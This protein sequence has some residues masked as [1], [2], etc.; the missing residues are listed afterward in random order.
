MSSSG[1]LPAFQ[2]QKNLILSQNIWKSNFINLWREYGTFREVAGVECFDRYRIDGDSEGQKRMSKILRQPTLWQDTMDDDLKSVH[3]VF[4]L[5]KLIAINDANVSLWL[6][7]YKSELDNYDFDRLAYEIENNVIVSS[8]FYLED[9]SIDDDFLDHLAFSIA[10]RRNIDL[11]FPNPRSATYDEIVTLDDVKSLMDA[12]ASRHLSPIGENPFDLGLIQ[13]EIQEYLLKHGIGTDILDQL[14]MD[15]T[16]VGVGNVSL[17]EM[18]YALP[19]DVA[20][21]MNSLSFIKLIQS[22]LDFIYKRVTHWYDVFLDLGKLILASIAFYFQQYWL[23]VSLLIS[24]VA[25]KVNS[26]LLQIVSTIVSLASGDI[27]SLG[28]MGAREAIEL[29]Q[30]VYALYVEISYTP[31]SPAQG[32]N[33]DNND[34]KM[35][36]RAPY[37]AYSGVY[38]YESLTSVDVD[39]KYY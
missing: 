27:S 21:H 18:T 37:D 26:R 19:V 24:F 25:D 5:N 3:L 20:Q 13:K 7:D 32:E 15:G 4:D 16:L 1:T 39:V 12:L 33:T 9:V 30:N 36:Y 35:F 14:V 11:T 10:Q 38:D 28:E 17:G 2:R 31:P 8:K 22:S 29:L 6:D 34:Q 23:G